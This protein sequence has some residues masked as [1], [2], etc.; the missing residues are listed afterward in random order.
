MVIVKFY[1]VFSIILLFLISESLAY[2][3][4]N[5]EENQGYL[6]LK[7]EIS[8]YGD[9]G[10]SKDF[11]FSDSFSVM[12]WI[13]GKNLS[14]TLRRDI[15]TKGKSGDYE[16]ALAVD[17][18]QKASFIIFNNESDNYLTATGYNTLKENKWYHLSGV[19]N[20]TSAFIYVNGVLEEQTTIPTGTKAFKG[21]AKVILGSRES[22]GKD[23]P[24]YGL[25]DDILIYN[26]SISDKQ[27]RRLYNE[28]V[29]GSSLGR[30]IPVLSY[31]RVENPADNKVIV[32]PENFALQ[33]QYLKNRNFTT[34]NYNNYYNWINRNFTM[35]EKPIII[36]FDDGFKSV[37]TNASTIMD[38]YGLKAVLAVITSRQKNPTYMNW[39]EIKILMDKGWEIESHS[40][41]HRDMTSLSF[42]ERINEFNDS[43]RDIY[44][45][46]S[47]M[48]LLWVYPFNINN[49]T[50]D[51]E[52]SAFYKICSGSSGTN[53]E[54]NFLFKNTNLTSENGAPIGL[55]R[56][57]IENETTLN[58]LS[59]SI[60]YF[61]G[62]V[63]SVKFS[64]I[65]AIK[66]IARDSS[67]QGN[68]VSL[69]N[70]TLS[71]DII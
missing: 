1:I 20:G 52:C 62:I 66:G 38:I 53:K 18:K 64:D 50:T 36:I 13:N 24:F 58:S 10:S 28:S 30:S 40:V 9:L 46:L 70:V 7:G 17:S 8:S 55:R 47:Y 45:N 41:T 71:I 59:N 5:E 31:H 11:N 6:T 69:H 4:Y 43:R 14:S 65:D 61:D 42:Q 60:D 57:S 19:F 29:H 44:N 21:T 2:I 22:I 33:M 37:F 27:I 67:S 23:T 25:I 3:Q 49:Y 15:I 26:K 48:P 39:G 63:A 68:N 54:E 32:T 16:W 56:I 51:N 12:A 34:I 35:P